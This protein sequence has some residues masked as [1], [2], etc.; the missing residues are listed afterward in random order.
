[1]FLQQFYT[2]RDNKILIDAQQASHFAKDIARDFN[3]IHDPDA[4]RFCV[5]GD[6]LFSIVLQKYGLSQHMRFNFSGM[7][8]HG[9][10]LNFPETDTEQFD[11]IG[12]NQKVYLQVERHGASNDNPALIE[13]FIR[14]YVAFSGP[15]FPHVLVPLMAKHNVMIN[16]ERPLVIYESMSFEFKQLNF[17]NPELTAAETTLEVKGKRGDARLHFN[18]VADHEIVGSGFKKLV[19]SGMREY[20]EAVIGEFVENYLAHM[21]AYKGPGA[22]AQ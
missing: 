6:L 19:I 8:G 14:N 11:I 2:N 7:V 12:D 20:D 9:V 21:N 18:I 17:S 5:P 22:N 16:T 10:L 13:T 4:K 3:P 15:N 1:M